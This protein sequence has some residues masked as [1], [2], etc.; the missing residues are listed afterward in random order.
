MRIEVDASWIVLSV[1]PG[2][3]S[4][5]FLTF[6][7]ETEAGPLQLTA[8]LGRR[9]DGF[10]IEGLTGSYADLRLT[11]GAMIMAARPGRKALRG[12]ASVWTPD[13]L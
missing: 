11:G 3:A 4:P 6:D 12:R 9:D 7:A 1:E 10:F 8:G 2:A 5:R 13:G